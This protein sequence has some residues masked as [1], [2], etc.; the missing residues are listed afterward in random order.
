VSAASKYV[1]SQAE[2]AA[3]RRNHRSRPR[4]IQG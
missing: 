4:I 2:V 1:D 3:S